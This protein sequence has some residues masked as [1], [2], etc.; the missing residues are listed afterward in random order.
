MTPQIKAELLKVRSTR[1]TAGLLT[2]MILLTLC[3]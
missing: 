3:S 1:T 2:A